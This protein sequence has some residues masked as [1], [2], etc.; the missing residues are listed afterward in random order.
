MH[1]TRALERLSYAAKLAFAVLADCLGRFDVTESHGDLCDRLRLERLAAAQFAFYHPAALARGLFR[2]HLGTP[3][4][5]PLFVIAACGQTISL[6]SCGAPRAGCQVPGG[7][8][9][10]CGA[11]Y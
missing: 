6:P 11:R 7:T 1:G 10:P 2:H 5:P 4:S 8:W 9:P 3:S